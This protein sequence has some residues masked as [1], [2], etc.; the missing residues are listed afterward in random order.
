[1]LRVIIDAGTLGDGAGG[2]SFAFKGQVYTVMVD[3]GGLRVVVVVYAAAVEVV[4]YFMMIVGESEVV[5]SAAF[6]VS[7]VLGTLEGVRCD[8]EVVGLVGT[9]GI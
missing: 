1:M 3:A 2:S 6:R 5:F 9:L 4:V 7:G 8:W